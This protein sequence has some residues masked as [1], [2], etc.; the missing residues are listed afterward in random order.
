MRTFAWIAAFAFASHVFP[1]LAQDASVN[2][3]L[4]RAFD[5][6]K[7]GDHAMAMNILRPLAEGGNALAQY[8]IGGMYEDG[9]G[10]TKSATEALRW[11]QRAAG[12]NL[13]LAQSSIG[14]LNYTGA[15]GIPKNPAEAVK[16]W[17]LAAV[18]GDTDA[19]VNLANALAAGEGVARDD[20]EAVKWYRLA[21]NKK[22]PTALYNLGVHYATGR[23]VPGDG[24]EA[25]KWWSLAAAAGDKD[26]P[27]MLAQLEPQM[28][29]MQI[30]QAKL[31]A[32]QWKP[33]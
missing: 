1:A 23:G 11:Y 15:P 24:L 27:K 12:Q 9:H 31:R 6:G 13:S 20:A 26:A 25:H 5:A 19:Q 30:F 28:T 8:T 32:Q 29:Q 17:R 21:A 2:E 16:W 18:Q 14:N 22:D 7:R 10:V 33:D 4:Y 3:Q